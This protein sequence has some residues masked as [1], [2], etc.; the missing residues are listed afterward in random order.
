M[1]SFW[2]LLRIAI[3]L[4]VFSTL[5][6]HCYALD[7]SATA[8]ALR[9][10]SM[11]TGGTLPTSDPLFAQLVTATQGGNLLAAAQTAAQSPYFANYLARR[12]ALQMQ[13]PALDAGIVTDNDATAFL[14]AHFIGAGG[15]KASLSTL[16]SENA[17]YLVNVTDAANVVTQVHVADLKPDQLMGVNW[18]TDLVRVPGQ[19]AKMLTLDDKG[20][21]VATPTDIPA[22]HVGGYTTLSD[23]KDDTSF[24]MFAT[25]AGTNLRMIEGIWKISTGL[26]LID[27]QSSNAPV[28]YVPRFVPEYD[29]NFFRGQGQPACISCHAGGM[30]SLTHGYATVAD[31]F[32]F[33][34]DNGLVFNSAPTVATMKS[35]GSD[36][37][38]R[39][40]NATCDLKKTK[41]A[42]C[43][44]DSLG[45][46]PNQAWDVSITWANSGVLSRMGW[47][48]A[49]SGQGLNALGTE[50]GKARIIYEFMTKRVINEICPLGAFT[51]TE[52]SN[53]AAS[54]NPFMSPA[55]SDD[56]RTIVARVAVHSS[57]Q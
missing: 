6:I 30:A 18:A 56:I 53:I 17:T 37:K 15:T 14:M 8:K 13:N 12:L 50:L 20:K 28:Q 21:A 38:K 54:A 42:A 25:T 11:I 57:C 40:N 47:T 44:P 46:D 48:G 29:S 27:V 35:L 23:R 4:S 32:D 33:D 9:I 36:P 16:W 10:S 39:Q 43:N 1:G 55:G 31:L 7:P 19:T 26:Q 24:A 51:A 41:T 49:T 52:I 3:G 5:S 22:K 2:K 34:K 45:V